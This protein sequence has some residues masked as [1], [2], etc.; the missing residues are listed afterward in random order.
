[1]KTPWKRLW[2]MLWGGVSL[3]F[4]AGPEPRWQLSDFPLRAVFSVPAEAGDCVLVT[5]PPPGGRETAFAAFDA[6]GNPLKFKIVHVDQSGASVLVATAPSGPRTGYT[7]YAGP[8]PGPAR[9]DATLADSS[10]IHVELYRTGGKSI[11]ASWERLHALLK[12]AGGPWHRFDSDGES[13]LDIAEIAVET[14]MQRLAQ[15]NPALP[16]DAREKHKEQ[17]ERQFRGQPWGMRYHTFL[18]CPAD[19]V[20]RFGV[21]PRYTAFVFVDGEPVASATERYRP[22]G[23][24]SGD[25]VFM[26]AGPH[27]LEVF[28]Y[29]RRR[30]SLD[31]GWSRGKA[32]MTAI[33]RSA[34]LCAA[35][36]DVRVE[37]L[38]TPLQPDFSYE[39]LQPYRL[40]PGTAP[41]V[42]V[43]FT[44]R[45]VDWLSAVTRAEWFFPGG[46]ELAGDT[47]LTVLTSTAVVEPV[48]RVRDGLVSP[49]PCGAC[50]RPATPATPW[51]PCW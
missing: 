51:R 23:W 47:V 25:P 26:K 8:G 28:A 17:Y 39:I 1:M 10:P 22:E 16:A 7:L 44:N 19:D 6:L 50:R 43:R 11:P 33:P 20:Y 49:R 34:L 18:T 29:A 30:A 45:S 9:S 46:R 13:R 38:Q 21:D 36:G 24:Q 4:G 37:R 12:G 35:A 5:L 3:A 15:S 48:L 2:I 14:A 41:F 32:D 31:V 40:R 27:R 42:P